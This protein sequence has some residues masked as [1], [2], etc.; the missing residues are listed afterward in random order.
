MMCLSSQK[1]VQPTIQLNEERQNQA[2]IIHQSTSRGSFLPGDKQWMIR[3]PQL[4]LKGKKSD[5]INIQE[6]N[7][8]Q[9]RRRAM[10]QH[11]LVEKRTRYCEY[12]V[13]WVLH[14]DPWDLPLVPELPKL[15]CRLLYPSGGTMYQLT[16]RIS[17]GDT[18]NKWQFHIIHI[19]GC[20]V[21]P[22]PGLQPNWILGLAFVLGLSALVFPSV[23]TWM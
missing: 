13:L 17:H 18:D 22:S 2:A 3:L 20:H 1:M 11:Y 9:G 19:H 10:K 5:Q 7:D 12:R 21:S 6:D 4:C 8:I 23:F 14:P 16:S 15:K